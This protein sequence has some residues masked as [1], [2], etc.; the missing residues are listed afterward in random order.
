MKRV[1]SS[2]LLFFCTTLFMLSASVCVCVVHADDD[3][4]YSIVDDCFIY[5]TY[6]Q[7]ANTNYAK[8][9]AD[10][11]VNAFLYGTT[12]GTSFNGY[13][14]LVSDSSFE[15]WITSGFTTTTCPAQYG[16]NP[17]SATVDNKSFYYAVFSINKSNVTDTFLPI[18]SNA[19]VTGNDK[20]AHYYVYGAGAVDPLEPVEPIVWGLVDIEGYQTQIAG[21]GNASINNVDVISWNDTFDTNSNDITEGNVRIRF[22]PGEYRASSK[23]NLLQQTYNDFVLSIIDATSGNVFSV[24]DGSASFSWAEVIDV[25]RIPFWSIYNITNTTEGWLKR[26]WIY[27]VRLEIDDYIGEWQTV[28]ASTSSGVENDLTIV[29]TTVITQETI[30]AIQNINSINST[31]NIW[32]INGTP[33]DPSPEYEPPASD[34]DKPWWAYLLE[35]I[36]NTLGI[37]NQY[38]NEGTDE[39]IEIVNNFEDDHDDLNVTVNDYDDIENNIVDDMN[40]NIEDLDIESDLI[41][42]NSFLSSA[43]WV[44]EQ[45]TRITTDNPIGSILKF[46]LVLGFVMIFLGRFK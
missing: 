27:Q 38:I 25:L 1:V 20:I 23:S 37:Q 14:Y 40:N 3:P 24:T 7:G 28:Y 18:N 34:D 33:V 6:T 44:A 5:L 17:Y 29:N 46:S 11:T 16:N 42:N 21:Q 41:E 19:P 32:I 2:L 39:S 4:T 26:G 45:Y 9:H 10:S 22:V 30:T 31:T 8:F 35:M 43:R 13:V 12:S 36:N 15:Y